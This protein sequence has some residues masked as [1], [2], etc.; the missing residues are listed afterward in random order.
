MPETGQ[1]VPTKQRAG[2][3]ARG[4]I[5]AAAEADKRSCSSLIDVDMFSYSTDGSPDYKACV[6]YVHFFFI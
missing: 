6:F 1:D 5:T 2:S 4:M 3:G